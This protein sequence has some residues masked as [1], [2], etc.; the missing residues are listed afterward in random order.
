MPTIDSKL[1]PSRAL[2][3]TGVILRAHD[4]GD[5]HATD[6]LSKL[7]WEGML[8]NSASILIAAP[9]LAEILRYR[10]GT[11]FPVVSGVEV[12]DFDDEAARIIGEKM[13]MDVLIEVMKHGDRKSYLKF[14]T[15]I[16]ACAVRHKA[17]CVVALDKE[18]HRLAPHAGIPVRT[19]PDFE[20]KA[21][22]QLFLKPIT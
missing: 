22:T 10:A 12:V 21:P 18:H 15:L 5:P 4:L 7:V 1:L 2:L 13:P 17:E 3:D 9:S 11:P 20:S 19:P 16:L 6:P 14:D 8:G